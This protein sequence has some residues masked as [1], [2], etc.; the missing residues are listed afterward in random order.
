[1]L[2]NAVEGALAWVEKEAEALAGTV[3]TQSAQKQVDVFL[4]GFR[5]RRQSSNDN[6]EDGALTGCAVLFLC[7][8]VPH[9]RSRL[10]SLA[11]AQSQTWFGAYV[12]CLLDPSWP[13][14]GFSPWWSAR[15]KVFL[16]VS[17]NYFYARAHTF[18]ATDT[19]HRT[20]AATASGP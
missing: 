1:M 17:L 13:I 2:L 16:N 10:H 7:C 6:T 15:I 11:V 18:T 12:E 14:P 3:L 8:C 20:Y 9:C 5:N 19:P 4:T